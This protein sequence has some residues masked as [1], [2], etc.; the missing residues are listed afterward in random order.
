MAASVRYVAVKALDRAFALCEKPVCEPPLTP[1]HAQGSPVNNMNSRAM[2]LMLA[3]ALAMLPS[4]TFAQDDGSDTDTSTGGLDSLYSGTSSTTSV[5]IAL[6]LTTTSGVVILTSSMGN[7]GR[8]APKGRQRRALQMYLNGNKD[9]VIDAQAMGAGNAVSDLA[10][11]FGVPAGHEK[12]MGLAMRA[13]HKQLGAIL[14]TPCDSAQSC[15]ALADQWI[16]VAFAS[17]DRT[18]Q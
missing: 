2:A 11:L 13:E 1:Q 5:F 16:D 9:G 8:T 17:L 3:L 18:L 15:D 6:P 14:T 10:A 12:A 7:T 4:T